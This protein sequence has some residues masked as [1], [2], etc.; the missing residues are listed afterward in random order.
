M[1]ISRRQFFAVWQMVGGRPPGL[2]ACQVGGA[3][4]GV[5]KW[6]GGDPNWRRKKPVGFASL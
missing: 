4:V 3:G 6:R 1:E 2:P 5:Q